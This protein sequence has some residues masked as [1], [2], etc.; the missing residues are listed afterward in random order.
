MNWLGRTFGAACIAITLLGCDSPEDNNFS[1]E[2]LTASMAITSDNIKKRWLATILHSMQGE[3]G[4]Y[5]KDAAA[6]HGIEIGYADNLNHAYGQYDSNTNGVTLEIP[7]GL[8][9]ETF[10]ELV[11][12]GRKIMYHELDHA[13]REHE[14][15]HV[16]GLSFEDSIDGDST[17][18]EAIADITAFIGMSE[19]AVVGSAPSLEVQFGVTDNGLPAYYSVIPPRMADTI[20]R[21]LEEDENFHQQPDVIDKTFT[22]FYDSPRSEGYT[23]RYGRH[24]PD[25][26]LQK[27]SGGEDLSTVFSDYRSGRDISFSEL[28]ARTTLIGSNVPLL[29]GLETEFS[30]KTFTSEAER[31]TVNDLLRR[32]EFLS[33]PDGGPANHLTRVTSGDGGDG[34]FD[35][36]SRQ[37]I[38]EAFEAQAENARR[39]S[40][41]FS[42]CSTA[43]YI[44][45]EIRS[46][47]ATIPG[48]LSA[49]LPGIN[50][51]V[52]WLQ[53]GDGELS[54]QDRLAAKEAYNTIHDGILY[55]ASDLR[56]QVHNRFVEGQA[57]QCTYTNMWP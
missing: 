45:E 10:D 38:I 3:T 8:T 4:V 53:Q 41:F 15:T 26:F 12:T 51:M 56:V 52:G 49:V 24:I 31:L 11:L 32:K 5:L 21:H 34:L 30:N 50:Q 1:V 27:Y 22:A 48:D 43:S 46:G 54:L 57:R 18:H 16:R 13:V 7:A 40:G 44:P 14:S 19:D 35:S 9:E 23:L 33:R 20:F 6:R 37:Q 29:E 47:L 36:A 25:S 2:E 42:R 55:P 28:S 17:A 39:L